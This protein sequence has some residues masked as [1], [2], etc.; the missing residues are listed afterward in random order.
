SSACSCHLQILYSISI[1]IIII[2]VQ[3]CAAVF[4]V[5]CE[6]QFIVQHHLSLPLELEDQDQNSYRCVLNNSLTEQTQHLDIT[7]LSHTC[8]DSGCN[9]AEAVFRLVVTA[10][11]GV[12]AAAAVVLLLYDI[13]S[14]RAE[15]ERAHV[16][17]SAT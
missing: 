14:R 12:A 16:P 4:S 6:K 9:S 7:E 13:R 1:I 10:L 17:T 8:S 11:V 15:Q 2:S 5:E 3:A